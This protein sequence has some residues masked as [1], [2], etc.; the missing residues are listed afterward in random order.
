MFKL[1]HDWHIPLICFIQERMSSLNWTRSDGFFY[2]LDSSATRASPVT[3][4]VHDVAELSIR[5]LPRSQVAFVER[6]IISQ[7]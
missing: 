3:G 4:S 6:V 1:Y 2:I 5:G 7:S